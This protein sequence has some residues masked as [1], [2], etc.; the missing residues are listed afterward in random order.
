M[1][2]YTTP[3][4]PSTAYKPI[5][6]GRS[7]SGIYL[8]RYQQHWLDAPP[9]RIFRGSSSAEKCAACDRGDFQLGHHHDC[10]KYK[11]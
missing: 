10:P 7:P 4:S 6:G 11:P 8:Y 9:F 5:H 3:L 2:Q 1:P